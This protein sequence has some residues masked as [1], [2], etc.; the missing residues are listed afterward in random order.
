MAAE[1]LP[2]LFI[3][4]LPLVSTV[5]LKVTQPAIYYGELPNDHVFVNTKT[6][7][8]DY[9]RGEDN[10]FAAYKG[11]GGVPLSNVFRRL[12]FAIRFRSTDTFFSPLLTTESRV[13]MNRRIAERVRRIAPFLTYDRD[14]YL[15]ISE[16]RLVWM[17]DVYLTSSRYPYSTSA[18][19]VNYIRNAIKITIDAYHGT[20][21][22]HLLDPS[23]PIAQTI[24]KMF[25]ALLQPMETHAGRP[26]G[27]AALSAR[28]LRGAGRHVRDVPHAEPGGVLQPRGSVGNPGLRRRRPVGRRC[29]PTTR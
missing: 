17:Q 26:E 16:G 2:V 13:M 12:M 23:D 19:G 3:R 15:T 11:S 4:D 8:F 18:G 5:D 28:N 7:E 25:P 21:T 27:A 9:P 29:P 1:G 14:P 24:G 22:F 10:V 20:T 6:E